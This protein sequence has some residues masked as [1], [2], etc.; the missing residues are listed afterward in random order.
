MVTSTNRMTLAEYLVYDN[1]TDQRYELVAGVIV[2]M[3]PESQR[4]ILIALFLLTQFLKFVPLKQ[5]SNKTEIVVGGSQGTIRLP[6]LVLLT[7]ELADVM[8]DQRRSTI[9]LDL[10]PPLLVVEVVSPGKTN[11]D[12]DYRYKRSEYAARGIAEYWIVDPLR[13]QVTVLTLVDGLYEEQ[14]FRGDAAIS[15]FV[16]P[17]LD[18]LPALEL[19]SAQI[20]Q[21]GA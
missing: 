8:Q 13:E 17:A 7:H 4:N 15:S 9:T 5:L 14:I 1:G 6:D 3:P 20:F 11:A 18:V 2:E 19:T 21:A 16:L 10:P 12:R